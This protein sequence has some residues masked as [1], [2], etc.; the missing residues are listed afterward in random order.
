MR[1]ADAKQKRF[2]IWFTDGSSFYHMG[3]PR[4]GYRA[5]HV[6]DGETLQGPAHP[7]SAQAAEVQA[8]RAVLGYESWDTS[9]TNNTDSDSQSNHCVAPPL[10]E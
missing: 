3:N 8:V 7:H 1:L 4:R 2:A 9:V 6:N 5:I 10:V